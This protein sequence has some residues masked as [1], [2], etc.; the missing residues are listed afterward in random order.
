[1]EKLI[2]NND[3]FAEGAFILNENCTSDSIVFNSSNIFITQ[4]GNTSLK[5]EILK[6]INESE[7]VIKVC[8][9]IL[10]DREIF[11]KLLERAKSCQISIFILTQLDTSKLVNTSLLTE[12]ESRDQTN[13]THLAYIKALY[14]NGAHVRASNS[15][16]AKFIVSDRKIGFVMSANLTNPSLILNTESGLYIDSNGVEC[17]DKLFDVIFQKGTLYRQYITSS[18]KTKGFVVQN[19]ITLKEEWLPKTNDNGIKYSYE[20]LT[21]NLYEEIVSIIKSAKEYLYISTYS[22]V[23]LENLP[24][25]IEEI[26][27]ARKRGVK[28]AIFC[29]GMNY[30]Q[31]H[32]FS[33]NQLLKLGCEIYADLYNH[34][35]GIINEAQGLL[36]TANIDGLHG[37]KNGFEVGYLLNDLQRKDF[38]DL[39]KHLIKTSPYVFIEKPMRGQLF[40]TYSF[41]EQLKNIKAPVFENDIIIRGKKELLEKFS[42]FE[43]M[44]L[45]YGKSKDKV[46]QNFIIGGNYCFKCSYDKGMFNVTEKINMNYNIE[47]YILK[48]DNLKILY[49]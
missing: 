24:E 30:R 22:I 35:K 15:A 48:Y 40:A 47:K 7:V 45:F 28:I 1:M 37:L 4:D 31:D 21:N 12:E 39:H 6:L 16:H 46:P 2:S 49:I 8:S 25:F 9:F 10:T 3:Y 27:N 23:K 42:I 41:Y 14:D 5:T 13:S 38:L 34:S 19:E 44:P 18:K 20:N 17:L 32:L 36:F 11:E 29:R 43:T 26:K 33:C